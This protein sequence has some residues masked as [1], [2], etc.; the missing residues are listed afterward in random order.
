[1]VPWA[2]RDGTS[3]QDLGGHGHEI[4]VKLCRGLGRRHPV[5]GFAQRHRDVANRRVRYPA[6]QCHGRRAE[7]RGEA[8]QVA[9]GFKANSCISP[10]AANTSNTIAC[11][12]FSHGQACRA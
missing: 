9:A 2:D 12:R 5:N 11:A 6:S 4:I 7:A 10:D 1:V 8:I 3:G